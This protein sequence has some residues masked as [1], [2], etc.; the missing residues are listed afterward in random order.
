MS[1]LAECNV[2]EHG[3]PGLINQTQR[4]SCHLDTSMMALSPY[5][6]FSPES[7]GVGDTAPR[8]GRTWCRNSIPTWYST[9]TSSPMAKPIIP[10]DTPYITLVRAAVVFEL[11]PWSLKYTGSNLAYCRLSNRH[12]RKYVGKMTRICIPFRH[13]NLSQVDIDTN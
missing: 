2:L 5:I 11:I 10:V 6:R 7:P 13:V 12:C 1:E 4:A 8:K 3:A 9:T